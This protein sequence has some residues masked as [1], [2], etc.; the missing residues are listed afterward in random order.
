MGAVPGSR[1]AS[2]VSKPEYKRLDIDD[3]TCCKAMQEVEVGVE[4]G[5]TR[6]VGGDNEGV[7]LQEIFS[8]GGRSRSM[9]FSVLPSN[10]RCR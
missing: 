1:E 3:L 7:A 4:V 8:K 6:L 9:I 10:W 2:G 5:G